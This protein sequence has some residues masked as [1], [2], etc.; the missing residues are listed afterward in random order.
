MD[1]D[2]SVS[3]SSNGPSVAAAISPDDL[4]AWHTLGR[5]VAVATVVGVELPLEQGM[6]DDMFEAVKS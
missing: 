6:R 1:C 4:H 5:H 3:P 2:F